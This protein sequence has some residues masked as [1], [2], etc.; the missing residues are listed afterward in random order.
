MSIKVNVDELTAKVKQ[1]Y[2]DVAETPHAAYHFELGRPLAVRLG[3]DTDMI[4]RIPTEAVE[5]F[6]G[7]G[8]FFD[9]ADIARGQTVVDLGSGSGMDAFYAAQLIGPSG[10][11]I[12]VDF[13]I[14]QLTK[15]RRLAA[16]FGADR[17]EFR[18]GRIERLPVADTSVDCVISNGV[19]NLSPDKD[20]VFAEAARVL[21][22]GGRLAIADI[23]TEQS[24]TDAIVGNTDLWASCIGG[25]A[26]Q[27]EYRRAIQTAGLRIIEN[28][29]NPYEFTSDQARNASG[30]FGVKSVSLLA[31]KP[32]APAA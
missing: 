25:A 28:R 10:R 1:M 12:G 17:V 22:P 30:R 18:E 14:E 26:Q 23:V 9:L 20:G 16:E 5:S 7:V 19:I 27:D 11:V 15:A 8:Y 32:P 21:R 3:Y 6:A 24:L 29:P 4:D 31:I 13:T 2:R